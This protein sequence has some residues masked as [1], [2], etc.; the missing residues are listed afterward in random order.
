[1]SFII[2]EEELGPFSPL[3]V[4]CSDKKLTLEDFYDLSTNQGLYDF[5]TAKYLITKMLRCKEEN[6]YKRFDKQ[7]I[8]IIKD[9]NARFDIPKLYFIGIA[10]DSLDHKYPLNFKDNSYNT[11][12]NLVKCKYPV[13]D[14][15]IESFDDNDYEEVVIQNGD[16]DLL[17]FLYERNY[18]S[19]YYESIYVT[20]VEFGH[21]HMLKW[22]Y[23]TGEF[24]HLER[25]PNWY[26]LIE[27]C[28]ECDQLDI[29]KWMLSIRKNVISQK[30]LKIAIREGK[31]KIIDWIRDKT[32]H[33][34]I[35][36]LSESI[37]DEVIDDDDL[38]K[39]KWLCSQEDH[40]WEFVK[41][42]PMGENISS[43]VKS[44]YSFE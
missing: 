32:E 1:M 11:L 20:L 33:K 6:D 18:T 5:F 36:V 13:P 22:I 38:D 44:N 26:M 12:K 23:S 43:W 8:Q 31:Y 10:E 39:F 2:P 17:E 15:L 40:H 4:D 25:D 30:S 3:K 14:W 24:W 35:P 19:W 7:E 41:N 28:I 16:L 29:L 9:I 21:L 27:R 37:Y 42:K 34:N